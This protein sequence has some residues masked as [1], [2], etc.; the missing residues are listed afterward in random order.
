MRLLIQLQKIDSALFSIKT[1]IEQL[2]VR[3]GSSRARLN[4]GKNACERIVTRYEKAEKEKRQK[5]SELEEYEDKI[6]KLKSKSTEVKTNK[7]YE[8]HL[9]EIRN[10]E[11]KKYNLEDEILSVMEVLDA[12]TGEVDREKMKLREVEEQ[13][14]REERDLEDEKNRLNDEMGTYRKQRED[15]TAGIE[16]DLYDQYMSVLKRSG[17]LAVVQTK[18]EVCLGCHTNIPPQLFS[19]IRSS[20]GIFTC[21][22]CNRFLFYEDTPDSPEVARNEEGKAF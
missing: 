9:K 12:I 14:Q 13:F 11:V 19:D 10:F 6:S 20:D 4:E 3:L 22:H 7:E 16:K 21:Y 2:P 5:E 15:L 18:N 8:A 17:G 1:E